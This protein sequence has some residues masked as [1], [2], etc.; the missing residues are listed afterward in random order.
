MEETKRE[1]NCDTR[2]AVI[3]VNKYIHCNYFR[4]KEGLLLNRELLFGRRKRNL[5]SDTRESDD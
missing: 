5:L 3:S 4:G 2:W 1:R